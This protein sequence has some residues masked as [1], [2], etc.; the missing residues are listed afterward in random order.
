MAAISSTQLGVLLGGQDRIF[1]FAGSTKLDELDR[2]V[3]RAVE[4]CRAAGDIAGEIEARH[5]GTTHLFAIGRLSESIA[6]NQ[7]LL[8]QARA[9][10]DSP[11]M[12]SIL[13]RLANTEALVGNA[14][15][16]D[17]WLA[18][19]EVLAEQSGLRT[20]ALQAH[21]PRG[22]NF[23]F[24]GDL[25]GA[26][27]VFRKYVAAAQ[28]AGAV[29]IQ[30]SAL[31]F[32]S[33]AVHY[34][35]K[36][37][38]AAEALDQAL[39]LSEASGERWNRTELYAL[40][41]RMALELRDLI[42]SEVFINR[43][44]EVLRDDDVTAISEVFH[45][46]GELRSVQGRDPEAEAAFRR[47]LAAVSETEYRWPKTNSALVLAKFLAARGRIDEAAALV[48]ERERSV[49]STGLRL[50]DPQI[51]EIHNLITVGQGA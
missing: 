41:S 10:G 43:A 36:H 5:L 37:S 11:R 38:E 40:R 48:D 35:G 44:L 12:A 20:V 15:E 25:A 33:Y 9:I 23:M 17:R 29:Q 30:M 42:T 7:R 19:A 14:P 21:L 22:I 4:A 28:D 34:Q 49:R 51:E 3:D 18:E 32:L 26:E 24:R 1:N 8:E 39:A 13:M 45:H 31:R 6:A 2:L 27:A 46:L 47:G 16:V 50:W